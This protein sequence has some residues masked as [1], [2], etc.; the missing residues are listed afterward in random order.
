MGLSRTVSLN[1]LGLEPGAATNSPQAVERRFSQTRSSLDVEIHHCNQIGDVAS[2]LR[3]TTHV[4]ALEHEW[5]NMYQPLRQYTTSHHQAIALLTRRNQDLRARGSFFVD[6]LC[7]LARDPL[8]CSTLAAIL[9]KGMFR[10]SVGM[11]DTITTCHLCGQ[12]H[13]RSSPCPYSHN[14]RDDQGRQAPPR[15]NPPPP[16]RIRNG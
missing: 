12:R 15:M 7:E 14:D 4:R 9:A 5:N 3:A 16:K 13:G 1:L 11:D 6:L 2:A 10:P 8:I